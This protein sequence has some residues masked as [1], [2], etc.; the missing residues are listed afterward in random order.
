MAL[1]DLLKKKLAKREL[2]ALPSSF[3]IIGSREK[4]VATVEINDKIKKRRKMIANAIMRQH[5]NVKS[6]LLKESE[7]KGVYRTREYKVIAG[8]A[9]SEVIHK[10]NNCRFAVDIQKAY[11]SQREGTERMLI[12]KIVKEN[13]TV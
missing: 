8:S 7:R 9:D 12:A 1:K 5:K 2:K 6:A 13:E 10:E 3:D 4:A 11:F